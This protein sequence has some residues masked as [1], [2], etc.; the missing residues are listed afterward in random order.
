MVVSCYSKWWLRGLGGWWL[1]DEPNMTFVASS[2]K[3][4]RARKKIKGKVS[5]SSRDVWKEGSS[6][7]SP[8]PLIFLILQLARGA[9]YD[10]HLTKYISTWKYSTVQQSSLGRKGDD[11]KRFLRAKRLKPEWEWVMRWQYSLTLLHPSLAL[12]N[13]LMRNTS[14]VNSHKQSHQG[15][16]SAKTHKN[17][18]WCESNLILGKVG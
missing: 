17:V 3:V 14:R 11:K 16:R 1:T 9:S 15:W 2:T 18:R 4:E 13:S 8:Y 12:R 10:D 6:F 7:I 5:H